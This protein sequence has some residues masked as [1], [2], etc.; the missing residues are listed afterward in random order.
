MN[1]LRQVYD[2]LEEDSMIMVALTGRI[3]E[4]CPNRSYSNDLLRGR[5][6]LKIK[7]DRVEQLDAEIGE[8]F[9]I[10]R[11]NQSAEKEESDSES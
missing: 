11:P 1:D 7:N 6:F 2:R 3:V 10:V 9:K 4:K 5:C 8:L